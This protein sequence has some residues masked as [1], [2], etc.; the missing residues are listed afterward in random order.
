[1][2]M[3]Q[4]AL[5][6]VCSS[7]LVLGACS[8]DAPGG[9]GED[10]GADA[11]FDPGDGAVADTRAAPDT[12]AADTTG[13]I[14]ARGTAEPDTALPADAAPDTADT[15]DARPADTA[16]SDSAGAD[17]ASEDAVSDAQI[18]PP[19]GDG[20]A[21]PRVLVDPDH[22]GHYDE[23]GDVG[24]DAGLTDGL[25]AT[26]CGLTDPASNGAGKE[27]EV[28]R[29]TAPRAGE[30]QV[31]VLADTN[32]DVFFYVLDGAKCDV[33]LASN[34]SGGAADID[35]AFLT[36]AAGQVIAI[37]VDGKANAHAG[38]YIVDVYDCEGDCAR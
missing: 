8:E 29:F 11:L 28:W 9:Q 6:V 12:V 22:D 35:Q 18:A 38:A 20:C 23:V 17:G 36:L 27:D 1:M 7:A 14:D 15:A 5:W 4:A 21:D 37:V 10:A 24:A 3:T 26:A 2:K 32:I 31:S 34:D 30:Y 19:T 25:D 16:P 13:P 33:C